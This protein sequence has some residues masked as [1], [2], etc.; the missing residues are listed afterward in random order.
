MAWRPREFPN[1]QSAWL[2]H[3]PFEIF[4]ISIIIV[5]DTNLIKFG[6]M[7]I[8]G[9]KPPWTYISFT[10]KWCENK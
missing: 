1:E 7:V 6:T 9:K 2:M 5:N 10:V 4:P 8:L 3:W